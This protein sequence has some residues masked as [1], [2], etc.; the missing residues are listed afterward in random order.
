H[1]LF[2]R[3]AQR[4]A[5]AIAVRAG[6][7]T[8]SY[9]QLDGRA[10]QLAHHLIGLGVGPETIVGVCLPRSLELS[11]AL[12]AV[13]KAGGAYLPLDPELPAQRLAYMLRDAGA[14]I[15]LTDCAVRDAL[16][17]ADA[18]TVRL[19]LDEHAAALAAEPRS[20][21]PRRATP[22]DTAYVIYTSGSSGEPKAVAVSHRAMCN[23]Q[24]WA[25]GCMALAPSQRML[26]LITTGFDA[27]VLELFTPL[28]AGATLTMAPA[29]VQRDMRALVR[30]LRQLAITHLVMTPSTARALLEEPELAHCTSVQHL[31]LGGEPLSLDLVRALRARLGE[32][33]ITHCYGPTEAATTATFHEVG[34]TPDGTGLVPIG[35]PIDNQRC[36]VLDGT[37][38][39]VPLGVVGELYIGGVGLARGYLNRPEHTAERFVADPWQSGERLYRTGDLARR[40]VDGALLFAGRADSQVKIRGQRI[41]PG[42]IE[43]TL[44]RCQ[45]VRQAAIAAR[46]NARGECELVACVV[47]DAFDERALREQLRQWLPAGLLPA[48]LVAVPALPLLP[49][50]KLDVRAWPAPQADTAAIEPPLT[51]T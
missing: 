6:E 38:Q 22:H 23:H 7:H 10:N 32:L 44:L 40:R 25:L 12:L 9:A 5:Q 50:G 42:E 39:P 35:R 43:A 8:L 49:S 2:E 47:A 34:A 33:R 1:E 24:H 48:A 26:Q 20:A 36:Q 14:R 19:A 29:G 3:Q 30:T 41:E 16:H 15:V 13:L 45:G 4:S 37:M 31:L 28:L 17:Q 27:S 51:D 46:A 18:G 21:P 11:V